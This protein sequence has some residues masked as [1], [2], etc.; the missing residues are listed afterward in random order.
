LR[1]GDAFPVLVRRNL[2]T[3]TTMT[4]SSHLLPLVVPFPADWVHDEWLAIVGAAAGRLRLIE[5]PLVDYRQH[6]GNQ[7]GAHRPG[8]R[9]KLGRLTESRGA[10]NARLLRRAEQLVE[11]LDALDVGTDR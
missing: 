5:R 6:G 1:D 4:I 11:R 9:Q 10:R 3:G 7:I 8:L 2:A